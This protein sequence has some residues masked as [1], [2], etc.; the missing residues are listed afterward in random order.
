MG[1]FVAGAG[2][3][4]GVVGR[5]VPAMVVV[6]W[7]LGTVRRSKVVLSFQGTKSRRSVSICDREGRLEAYSQV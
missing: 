7:R 3:R 4:G 1:W 5:S 6:V 2:A